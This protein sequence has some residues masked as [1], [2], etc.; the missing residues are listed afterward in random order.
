M[1]STGVG[2]LRFTQVK[3]QA[4]LAIA[5]TV[6][7]LITFGVIASSVVIRDM[8]FPGPPYAESALL[9]SV[10]FPYTSSGQYIG[11][12]HF[13]AEVLNRTKPA[14]QWGRIDY[15]PAAVPSTRPD[16]VSVNAVDD[17]TWGAAAFSVRTSRC[18]LILSSV[19][20]TDTKFGN[21]FYGVLSAGS[22]CLGS[23]ATPSGVTLASAPPE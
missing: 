1:A 16:M 21:T 3:P 13:T 15:V 18:Y 22:V 17:Y 6:G 20:P 5:L 14:A 8:Y 9:W 11:M 2:V 7:A 19:D 4:R 23:A 12:Q 10:P